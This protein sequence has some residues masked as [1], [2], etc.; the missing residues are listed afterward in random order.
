MVWRYLVSSCSICIDLKTNE[1]PSGWP[2]GLGLGLPRWRS[3]VRNPL[4]AKARD[5]PSGLSSSHRAC[6]A[7]PVVERISLCPFFCFLSLYCFEEICQ[8]LIQFELEPC[9]YT[10]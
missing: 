4:P 10:E 9:R 1:N 8:K 7:V 3:Q 2:S 5:L 6:L